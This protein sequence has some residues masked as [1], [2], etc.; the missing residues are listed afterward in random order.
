MRL[1]ENASSWRVNAIRKRD[2]KHDHSE[3]TPKFRAHKNTTKWCR[4]KVGS[5]HEVIWHE[6]RGLFGEKYRTGKCQNCS[7]IM[8]RRA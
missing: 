3:P 1:K 8:F 6:K 2:F 7:K 5:Q 4:G